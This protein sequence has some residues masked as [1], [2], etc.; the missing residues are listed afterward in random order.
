MTRRAKRVLSRRRFALPANSREAEAYNASACIAACVRDFGANLP[1][2]RLID[3]RDQNRSAGASLCV[4]NVS[5]LVI[6]GTVFCAFEPAA[7]ITSIGRE[8]SC[9]A[10]RHQ[11]ILFSARFAKTASPAQRAILFC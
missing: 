2:L 1:G 7:K 6:F 11:K 3:R 10:K 9:A 4:E 8:R 5:V